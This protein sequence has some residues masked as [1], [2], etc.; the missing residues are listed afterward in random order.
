MR[1]VIPTIFNHN[2]KEFKERLEKI[3]SISKDF[4]IDFMDGK[5]VGEKSIKVKETPNLKKLNKNFEAHLMT[6]KPEKKIGILKRKGFNKVIFHYESSKNPEKTIKKI[7][8]YGLKCFIAINPETSVKRIFHFLENADG[9]LVMGVHP[10]KERQN[11][12]PETYKKI[13]EIKKV[14]P[15]KTIQIDG[16]VNIPTAKRLKNLGV[17]IINTGSFVS[18]SESPKGNLEKLK[19]A[20]I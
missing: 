5:F 16:G 3:F 17:E 1:K 14:F 6:M 19:K 18:K 15:K 13:K 20:F 9:V 7:K 10:G 11:F 12:I 4:Q 2:K 8:K